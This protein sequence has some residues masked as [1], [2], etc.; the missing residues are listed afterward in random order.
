MTFRSGASRDPSTCVTPL[1]H[2][3]A[4]ADQKI[5]ILDQS[6]ICRRWFKRMAVLT[7]GDHHGKIHDVT[8]DLSCEIIIRKQGRHNLQLPVSWSSHIPV[9]VPDRSAPGQGTKKKHRCNEPCFHPFSSCF[10][11]IFQSVSSGIITRLS[12][13]RYPAAFQAEIPDEMRQVP[14]A[15][16]IP[17]ELQRSSSSHSFPVFHIRV[18]VTKIQ[19]LRT[20]LHRRVSPPSA[21]LTDPASSGHLPGSPITVSK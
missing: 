9:C 16:G 3:S 15:P 10:L 12:L 18:R 6:D 14:H 17:R 8:G 7:G 11:K 21:P 13:L 2:R 1:F 5:R 19:A 4:V 20:D